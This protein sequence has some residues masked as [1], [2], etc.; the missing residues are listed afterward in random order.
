MNDF[1]RWRYW[2][3]AVVMVLGVVYALPNAFLSIPGVQ[4]TAN[5]TAPPVDSALRAKVIAALA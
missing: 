3:V 4:I 1:P 5:R 2:L